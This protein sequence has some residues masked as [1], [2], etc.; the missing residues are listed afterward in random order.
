M[1]QR[2]LGREPRDEAK[3]YFDT[4]TGTSAE[5]AEAFRRQ[6]A[7]AGGPGPDV[8][9]GTPASL[10]PAWTWLREHAETVDELPDDPDLPEWAEPG[11][12]PR[13]F[14]LSPATLRLLDGFIHY[15]AQV[16]LADVP[17]TRWEFYEDRRRG[18]V[19]VDHQWPVLVGERIHVNPMVVAGLTYRA[20][21]DPDG[22]EPERILRV[23]AS[24]TG[25]PELV[26]GR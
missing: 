9:D 24:Q 3:R 8:L 4:W 16:L 25:Q 7:A 12:A 14:E 15:Y 11:R 1:P 22:I 6:V 21:A 17:G 20:V 26:A 23:Y 13:G 5:R 2:R 19:N 10:V 18:D